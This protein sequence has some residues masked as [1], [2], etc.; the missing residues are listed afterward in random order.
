MLQYA[1]PR[2]LLLFLTGFLLVGAGYVSAQSRKAPKAKP[3]RTSSRFDATTR[4]F[5]V[6]PAA[7]TGA[8]ASLAAEAPLPPPKQ[9]GTATSIMQRETYLDGKR[10]VYQQRTPV[11]FSAH[12]LP[13]LSWN[14]AAGAGTLAGYDGPLPALQLSG[15]PNVD[16]YVFPY[17]TRFAIGTGLWYTLR[18]AGY[19]HPTSE[20]GGTSFY[21]LSYLQ[22]P[23]TMKAFSETLIP[24]GRTYAQAGLT[25]DLKLTETALDPANNV[26]YRRT[27][28]ATQ[29]TGADC[30]L[31]LSVGYMRPVS[32][33]K[34]LII[35]FQYQRG[36]TNAAATANLTAR[37][38]LLALGAGLS[39]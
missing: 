8:T 28:N 35:S 14:S 10:P 23:L 34:S 30:S 37:H 22:L 21:Q 36:L 3:Q 4:T 29:F 18:R 17:N 9:T 2:L 1:W 16:W 5:V 33:R 27:N 11:R 32:K 19:V 31:L 13:T 15:G 24:G 20:K 12:L 7:P 39:F 6:S 38:N 26:L 25:A